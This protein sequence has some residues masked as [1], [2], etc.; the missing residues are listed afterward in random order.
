MSKDFTARFYI[1]KKLGSF[2]N[3]DQIEITDDYSLSDIIV[4]DTLERNTVSKHIFY[5]DSV[6]N[7]SNWEELLYLIQR[8]YLDKQRNQI[9]NVRL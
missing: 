9:Q 1:E 5:L 7:N 2:F 8:V 4:T 3:T 6:S